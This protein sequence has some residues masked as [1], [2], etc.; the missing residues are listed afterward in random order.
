MKNNYI[1]SY[2]DFKINEAFISDN[3]EISEI[4][5]NVLNLVKNQAPY[6]EIERALS[7]KHDDVSLLELVIDKFEGSIKLYTLKAYAYLDDKNAERQLD[8]MTRLDQSVGVKEIGE[9]IA[10]IARKYPES[11]IGLKIKN[12]RTTELKARP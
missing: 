1:K 8:I 6:E 9:L 4:A 3:L 2:E 11:P 7:V 10:I 12:V 5:N